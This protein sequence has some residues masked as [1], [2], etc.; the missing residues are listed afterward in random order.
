ML[1][2]LFDKVTGLFDKRFTL[3][4]LLP[5]FAFAA[6]CGALAA[7]MVGW[8][9][10]VTWWSALDAAR[11]VALGV[12]GAA[13]VVVFAILAGTQVV[14]TTRALEGYWFWPVDMT[15][16]RLGRTFQRLQ[17]SWLTFLAGNGSRSGY[18]RLYAAF[19]A[20]PQLLLPT[21]LGNTLLAAE[22]YA[23]DPERWGIDAV[24][25]W[26]RLYLI[27]PDGARTQVDDA[28]SGL[29]QMVVLT[30]LS[31]TFAAVA[32]ALGFAGLNPTVAASCTVGGLALSWL[33]YR[34][35]VSSAAVYG[36]LVRAC[37][38]LYRG[39]L[40]KQLGWAMPAR[41]ADERTLWQVLGKQLYRRGL[42][43]PQQEAVLGAPRLPPTE[44]PGLPGVPGS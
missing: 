9:R 44:P 24:F 42:D 31:G 28:R 14:A 15:L 11:Q 8:H 13:V 10:A 33:S 2:T 3:A 34:G 21:R 19:P 16:G 5:A 29:D 6:G 40:L 26:P 36:D 18:Q 39:D 32:F 12:A 27:L 25:W 22:S 43:N 35:A 37:Y 4:L 20:D 17:R 7:T 38:D 23:S 41:L 1:S 30:G